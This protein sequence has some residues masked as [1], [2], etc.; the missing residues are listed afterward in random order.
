MTAMTQ[1]ISFQWPEVVTFMLV[2]GRSAG[3]IV[4]APFWGSRVVPVLVRVWVALLLAVATYPLVRVVDFAGGVSQIA[5][6]IAL[7]GEIFLGLVLGWVAQL[8]FAG[9]RLAGHLIEIKSGLGLAQLVDPHD[10]G[11]SG[12]FAAFFDLLAGL[13]FFAINGHYLLIQALISSFQ[14]FPLAG[15]KFAARLAAGL[16]H[17]SGEIFTIALRVSAPVI[18]G[19]LL[20]NIVLGILS[21]ALP[22]MNVFL[23]AQPL[24][25]GFGTLLLL[26]S[27]P[28]VV[29]FVVRQL[30]LM[31]GVPGG[32]G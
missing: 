29:W 27:L 6:L 30:P 19:L 14:T 23:V 32:P 15:E 8:L 22:Q 9:M 16:I 12:L 31:S 3:L 2:F 20:S 5:L 13:V 7:A 17:S 10:S 4:S 26:L 25:F 21:R 11:H 28:A 18:I 1:W 24:Q